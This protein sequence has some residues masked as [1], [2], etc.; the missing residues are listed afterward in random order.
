MRSANDNRGPQDTPEYYR[1]QAVK[2]RLAAEDPHL[3][4]EMRDTYLEIAEQ[5]EEMARRAPE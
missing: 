1:A 2:A 4:H 3:T 5:W